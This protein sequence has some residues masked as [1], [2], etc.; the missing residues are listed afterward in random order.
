MTTEC[1]CCSS[2]SYGCSMRRDY[3]ICVCACACSGSLHR[4]AASVQEPAA[5]RGPMP[6]LADTGS[7]NH[8]SIMASLKA[9]EAWRTGDKA[10]NCPAAHWDHMCSPQL[11][12]AWMAP[13]PQSNDSDRREVH[14]PKTWVHSPCS[15]EQNNFFFF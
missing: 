12:L 8:S 3:S 4:P 11:Y 13:Q 1:V 2:Y 6:H 5:G 10:G 14:A 9:R 7:A 15:G